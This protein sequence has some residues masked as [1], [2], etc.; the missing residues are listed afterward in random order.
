MAETPREGAGVNASNE[1]RG[2]APAQRSPGPRPD[3]TARPGGPPA[4]P[5]PPLRQDALRVLAA[6]VASAVALSLIF[7]PFELW[8]LAFVALGPWAAAVCG[9]HRPWL[10]YWASYLIGFCFFTAN[11]GWLAPVTGLGYVALAAYLAIYWP[12]SAWGMRTARRYGIAPV[13]SLPVVWVACEFM[14]AWVMSGFPWLFVGHGLY[15]AVTLIQI[16]DIGG[17]YLVSALALLVSGWFAELVLTH[18]ARND[19]RTTRTQ[20][21]VGGLA[22]VAAIFAALGYGGTRLGTPLVAGPRVAVIQDDFPLSNSEPGELPHVIFASYM[23]I[24]AKAAQERPDLIVFPETPW[25]AVQ[26]VDFLESRAHAPETAGDSW[27]FGLHCHEATA[28]VARG[29]YA[30]VNEKIAHWE[31]NIRQVAREKKLNL[32]TD[33]PRLSPERGPPAPLLVGSVSITPRPDAVYPKELRYNSAL[34]YDRDGVQRRER[35]DKMHLVPFGEVVPFRYGR[36]HRVYQWLNA[37]SPFSRQGTIEYSLTPGA[38]QTVFTLDAENGTY[39]FG[40][41]ICYEDVMPYVSRRYAWQ[42]G[43]RRVDFLVNIS[44]DGW[45]AHSAELPQHLAIC[46]FRAVENRVPIARAVNTGISG[47]ID[48]L[49]RMHDLVTAEDGRAYGPGIRGFR[50]AELK[51]APS[52][53]SLYGRWGDW[54]AIACLVAAGALWLEGIAV[55][56]AAAAGRRIGGWFRR[57]GA[58]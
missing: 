49:G 47:F 11:L 23:S 32:T 50:I 5:L 37:L 20:L 21:F 9:T 53:T 39:R 28:A 3:G 55:R 22:S 52:R 14:R 6:T 35:Y 24:A 41:P 58:T 31:R 2:G 19:P 17:A 57:K 33:L 43:Q 34:L 42:G 30:V 29:E 15:R 38:A 54:F 13:W 45:F 44:N 1:A 46:V 25:S 12:M 4:V 26:N 8:P 36:F 40:V 51:L 27:A 7:P 10:G 18:E 16:A 48:P 56:W